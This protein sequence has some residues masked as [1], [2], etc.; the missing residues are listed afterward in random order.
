MLVKNYRRGEIFGLTR[1]TW[2][3][4]ALSSLRRTKVESQLHTSSVDAASDDIVGVNEHPY[5]R[6]DR[7]SG[8]AQ[9]GTI[10]SP[11]EMFRFSGFSG[12]GTVV[13]AC[14]ETT[15]LRTMYVRGNV[16]LATR[17]PQKK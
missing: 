16:V 15:R 13:A 1:G 7:S 9:T 6:V 12:L 2:V 10:L 4:A 5:M 3:S 8:Q 11:L 14:P 17:N